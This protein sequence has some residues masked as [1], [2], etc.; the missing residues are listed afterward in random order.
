MLRLNYQSVRHFF[1]T[2]ILSLVSRARLVL[3]MQTLIMHIRPNFQSQ[4]VFLLYAVVH[5]YADA[6]HYYAL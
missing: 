4:G 5:S 1:V 2:T 6:G 3:T